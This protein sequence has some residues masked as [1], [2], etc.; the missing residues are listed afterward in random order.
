MKSNEQRALDILAYEFRNEE[1]KENNDKIRRNI[2]AK[3]FNSLPENW[4]KDLRD[5]KNMVMAEVSKHEKSI[6]YIENKDKFADMSH[7]KCEQMIDDY[8]MKFSKITK[9]AI[10]AFIPYAIYIYYL[11]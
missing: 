3:V 1:V 6:Y 4:L 10:E 8:S 11:R 5:F 2:G 9:N 7:F